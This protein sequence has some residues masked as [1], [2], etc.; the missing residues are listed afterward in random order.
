PGSL[1]LREAGSGN[2]ARLEA[3]LSSSTYSLKNADW[4]MAAWFRRNTATNDD[5]IFH[6]GAGDGFSGDGDEMDLDLVAG[7]ELQLRHYNAANAQDASIA[8]GIIP[9]GK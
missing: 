3:L 4:T 2:V 8:T 7:G 6:I 1:S 5:F 9:A